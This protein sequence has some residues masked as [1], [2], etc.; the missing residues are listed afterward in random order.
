MEVFQVLL[1]TKSFFN[2]DSTVLLCLVRFSTT[3][4]LQIDITPTPWLT[5]AAFGYWK[6]LC[7]LS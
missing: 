6:N 1:L 3:Q 2:Q 5:L 4:T 7:Q